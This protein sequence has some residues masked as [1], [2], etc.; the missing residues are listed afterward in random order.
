MLSI[1]RH[2]MNPDGKS[3]ERKMN[4]TIRDNRDFEKS[5]GSRACP[6]IIN[7]LRRKHFESANYMKHCT[8][9]AKYSITPLS[10]PFFI[11]VNVKMLARMKEGHPYSIPIMV[12]LR[13]FCGEPLIN[14]IIHLGARTV[15]CRHMHGN[16]VQN[17][18]PHFP[19]LPNFMNILF[20]KYYPFDF[21]CSIIFP[22]LDV[23]GIF[24]PW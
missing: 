7:F 8:S 12:Q 10:P 1:H 15:N 24:P 6:F 14:A 5:Y 16:T 9:P 4:F 11:M 13:H 21:Q 22:T 20:R 17:H 23:T 3:H 18:I 2:F 19:I